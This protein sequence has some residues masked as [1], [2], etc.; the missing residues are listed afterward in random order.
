[1]LFKPGLDRISSKVKQIALIWMIC[2]KVKYIWDLEEF[3]SSFELL[4]GKGL[5]GFWYIECIYIYNG[6]TEKDK[7][8][9]INKERMSEK[10]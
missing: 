4:V 5:S 10:E 2:I 7:Y 3:S 8:I 1:M 6:E 9:K